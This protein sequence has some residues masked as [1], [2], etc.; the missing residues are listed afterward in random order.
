[1]YQRENEYPDMERKTEMTPQPL[2]QPACEKVEVSREVTEKML[3]IARTIQ[4]RVLGPRPDEKCREDRPVGGLMDALDA[5][6][7]KLFELA[8]VLEKLNE[9]L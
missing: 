2:P 9:V 8:G 4:E 5:L 7:D 3:Y 6:N 1:M